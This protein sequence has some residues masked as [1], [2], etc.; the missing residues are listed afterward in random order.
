MKKWYAVLGNPIHH[1]ISPKMHEY[2]FDQN[3]INASYI[4][5]L[6]ERD[7]LKQT[8]ESLRL[9]GCS[10]F[11]VTVPFKEEIVPLLDT[12]DISAELAG[13][14]NTVV[15]HDNQWVGYN[16][17]GLGLLASI[18]QLKADS[19]ILI[20]GAGGAARGIVAALKTTGHSQITITNRTIE[21]ASSLASEF[22]AATLLYSEV[23]DHLAHF[24]IVIQTTSVG[25][26]TL[27]EP[28]KLTNWHSHMSAVD[29]IYTPSETTFLRR[30]RESGAQTMNGLSMLIGQGALAFYYWTGVHP[31]QIEMKETIFSS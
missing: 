31:N 30:A 14:V 24:D 8:V 18:E 27:E 6:V 10:G 29:I 9:L 16:T 28:I 25:M 19:R 13:A 11:N 4:P 21:K 17:D 22:S 5:I 12:L 20:I 2:W 26:E 15:R 7:A 1:S 23:D 3:H